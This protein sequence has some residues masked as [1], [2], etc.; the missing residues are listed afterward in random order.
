M[1]MCLYIFLYSSMIRCT[2]VCVCVPHQLFEQELVSIRSTR[3]A[4]IVAIVVVTV[5]IVV[6]V[7]IVIE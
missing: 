2:V 7:V 6:T 4:T 1:F 5:A 3:T